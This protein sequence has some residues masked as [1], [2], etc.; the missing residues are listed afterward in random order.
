MQALVNFVFLVVLV[1][2]VALM[3]FAAYWAWSKVPSWSD[4]NPLNLLKKAFN[5]FPKAKEKPGPVNPKT[6]QEKEA[7]TYSN[8]PPSDYSDVGKVGSFFSDTENFLSYY[9]KPANK[10]G[11]TQAEIDQLKKFL[12]GAK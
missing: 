7:L 4:L 10:E 12:Q 6:K 3:F 9:F 2:I 5:S 1:F 11:Q 8:L